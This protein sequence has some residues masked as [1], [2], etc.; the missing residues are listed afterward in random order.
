MPVG[1]LTTQL[2][3]WRYGLLVEH[4]TQSVDSPPLHVLHDEWQLAQPS[5][6]S[7]SPSAHEL[8]HSLS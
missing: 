8:M 7:Y 6:A 4:V 5:S 1:Q 2:V 3:P